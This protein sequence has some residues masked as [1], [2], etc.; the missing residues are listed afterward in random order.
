MVSGLPFLTFQEGEASDLA[1][2]SLMGSDLLRLT[3]LPRT[4]ST[5]EHG[6]VP[7]PRLDMGSGRCHVCPVCTATQHTPNERDTQSCGKTHLISSL[8]SCTGKR[9]GD[10]SRVRRHEDKS[11]QGDSAGELLVPFI[12]GLCI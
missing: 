5:V 9:T 7:S 8:P 3:P 6:T 10:D 2:S 4:G 1:G 11:P 12:S